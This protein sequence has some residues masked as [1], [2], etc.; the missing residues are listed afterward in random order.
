M[1][2]AGPAED[3]FAPHHTIPAAGAFDRSVFQMGVFPECSEWVVPPHHLTGGVLSAAAAW[4]RTAIRLYTVP[5]LSPGSAG[6]SHI[7]GIYGILPKGIPA[8]I[9]GIVRSDGTHTVR[10]TTYPRGN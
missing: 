1:Y 6:V 9:P 10:Y 7:R 2:G 5:E 4:D 3:I 8:G